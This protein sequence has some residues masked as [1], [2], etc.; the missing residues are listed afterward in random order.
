MATVRKPRSNGA[1]KNNDKSVDEGRRRV[2]CPHLSCLPVFVSIPGVAAR[3]NHSKGAGGG[4]GRWRWPP[5]TRDPSYLC[6]RS[7][8]TI[9]MKN[10][11]TQSGSSALSG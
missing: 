7:S 4:G 11:E 1:P 2:P 3:I 6:H 8:V 9:G 10:R 5:P